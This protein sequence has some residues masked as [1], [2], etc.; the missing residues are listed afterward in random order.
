MAKPDPNHPQLKGNFAPIRM[1]CDLPDAIIRGELPADLN[2]TY[3]RNGPD[4]QFPPR[5]HHHWFGGDGMLHKFR[6]QDG[7][8]SYSNRWMRTLLRL[9]D[10]ILKKSRPRLW[11]K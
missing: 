4:P 9:K 8:V 10:T 5:G 11:K 6:I 7:R 3:Y 2:V 1:E